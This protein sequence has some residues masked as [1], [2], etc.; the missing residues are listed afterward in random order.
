MGA[1]EEDHEDQ[2]KAAAAGAEGWTVLGSVQPM[3]QWGERRL[4]GRP[5][6]PE[7]HGST[8]PDL[9]CAPRYHETSH[10]DGQLWWKKCQGHR[11]DPCHLLVKYERATHASSL[12]KSN[13]FIL[14][15]WRQRPGGGN[16]RD[17]PGQWPDGQS[18]WM[19][20]K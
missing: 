15:S 10:A 17:Q 5:H 12:G 9:P 14:L 16:V 18:I 4:D 11:S 6:P 19:Y 20:M 13:V 2:E 3:S 7:R 1:G 8:L